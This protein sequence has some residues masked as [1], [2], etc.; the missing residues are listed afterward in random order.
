MEPCN[1]IC[2]VRKAFLPLS[3]RIASCYSEVP[4]EQGMAEI[5]AAVRA[6]RVKR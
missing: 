1:R 5:E 6:E 2:W 3:S 4:V